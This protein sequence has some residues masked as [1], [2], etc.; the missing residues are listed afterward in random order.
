MVVLL[1]ADHVDHLL[2]VEL[3]VTQLCGAEIL[4]HIDGRAVL[5]QQHLLVQALTGEIDAHGTILV[6]V[7]RALVQTFLHQALAKQIGLGF[8]IRLVE[9]DAQ[10]L[11][12][13]VEAGIDPAVHLRP[14][15]ADLLVTRFPLAQ[16]LTSFQNQRG[17]VFCFV[18]RK[19]LFQDFFLLLLVMLIEDDIILSDE[20]IA[21]HTGTFRGFPFAVLQPREHRLA[22]VDTAVIDQVDLHHRV[23]A[24][25]E[26]LRHGMAEQVVADM[27]EVQRLVGVRRGVLDEHGGFLLGRLQPI[28]F[29]VRLLLQQIYPK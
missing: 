16:H 18:F 10:T 17:L 21:L 14:Q 15:L 2:R 28:T 19:S 11:V 20:M 8:V 13:L 22:D 23:A 4:R 27:P 25:F 9:V 24:R 3:L 29:I 1:V 7:E 12:G 5:A 26:N 6:F